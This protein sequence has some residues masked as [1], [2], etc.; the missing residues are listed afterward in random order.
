MRQQAGPP[1]ERRDRPRE[2]PVDPDSPFAALEALKRELEK[3]R[4]E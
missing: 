1:P 2:R 4:S 3:S